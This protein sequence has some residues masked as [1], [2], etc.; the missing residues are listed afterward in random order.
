M[1]VHACVEVRGEFAEVGSLFPPC[2]FQ[3]WSSGHQAKLKVPA[4]S[5][6]SSWSCERR[7][8]YLPA[9]V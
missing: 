6:P 8:L 4:P 1:S 7:A 2:Q 9:C 3:G 5:E